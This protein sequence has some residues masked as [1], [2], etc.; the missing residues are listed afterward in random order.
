MYGRYE[1][2]SIGSG[3]VDIMAMFAVVCLFNKAC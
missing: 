3:I 2:M 1:E